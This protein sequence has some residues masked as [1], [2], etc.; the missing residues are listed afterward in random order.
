[1]GWRN[2]EINHL[3]IGEL[4]A[5]RSDG[6][7]EQFTGA[8]PEASGTEIPADDDA[9]GLPRGHQALIRDSKPRLLGTGE[10]V[11]STAANGGGSQ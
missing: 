9:S 6:R 3:I 8:V 7:H 5:R 1:M 11:E 2:L 10:A 4:I